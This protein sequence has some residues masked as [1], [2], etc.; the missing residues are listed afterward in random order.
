M[1]HSLFN[2]LLDTGV[3]VVAPSV[4]FQSIVLGKEEYLVVARRDLR[5]TS[6]KKLSFSLNVD[7]SLRRSVSSL[8][9][10]FYRPGEKE[11]IGKVALL[12]ACRGPLC[13]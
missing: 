6:R 1:G 7:A 2:R 11:F 12:H 13:V 4:P 9:L 5:S 3:L 10:S 8:G